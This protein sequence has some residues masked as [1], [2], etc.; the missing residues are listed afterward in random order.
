MESISY[1]GHEI[2]REDG[3]EA[4]FAMFNRPTVDLKCGYISKLA[5]RHNVPETNT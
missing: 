2:F 3:S 5:I 1:T 4:G